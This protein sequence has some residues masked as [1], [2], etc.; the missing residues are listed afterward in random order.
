MHQRPD[1]RDSAPP[2]CR[3]ERMGVR[4]RGGGAHPRLP[5]RPD[6]QREHWERAQNEVRAGVLGRA[7]SAR[8]VGGLPARVV[9]SGMC[10]PRRA[11]FTR[12]VKLCLLKTIEFKKR[13]EQRYRILAQLDRS[14]MC[15]LRAGA[16][17]YAWRC[18]A[19]VSTHAFGAI[20]WAERR[21][22]CLPYANAI[23]ATPQQLPIAAIKNLSALDM[24]KRL[25]C[26][27][28]AAI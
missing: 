5:A 15:L 1:A 9:A 17:I 28:N 21:C 4:P 2:K 11:V 3:R 20:F 19:K 12:I 22:E 24:L 7:R 8:Q 14:S 27:F 25:F 13:T 10:I 6:T 23:S 26:M 16:Q 18:F